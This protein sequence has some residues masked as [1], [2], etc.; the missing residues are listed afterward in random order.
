[1]T[2]D[3]L[4]ACGH[5]DR[6][7]IPTCA[8]AVVTGSITHV[9][10]CLRFTAA[11]VKPVMCPNTSPHAAH[12]WEALKPA[13]GTVL[14][15]LWCI[16]RSHVWRPVEGAFTAGHQYTGAP[17]AERQDTRDPQCVDRWPECAEDEYNP[18]C[19]RFPKSC[20]CETFA[21]EAQPADDL[22]ITAQ[23]DV[24]TFRVE[25]IVRRYKDDKFAGYMTIRVQGE[26]ASS[27]VEP[28]EQRIPATV[29]EPSRPEQRRHRLCST[30][31]HASGSWSA[32]CGCGWK[33]DVCTTQGEAE[34]AVHDHRD[35]VDGYFEDDGSVQRFPDPWN[36]QAGDVFR[37]R[38]VDTPILITAVGENS[39]LARLYSAPG[40]REFARDKRVISTDY[41][42]W[43]PPEADD[44]PEIPLDTVA[45]RDD[46]GNMIH[47]GRLVDGV[48]Q[49]FFRPDGEAS[50]D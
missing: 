10:G 8:A 50:G 42:P 13:P 28:V 16:G 33:S 14:P 41:I 5:P 6:L 35:E 29:E 32:T 27:K 22:R 21:R 23:A 15:Q 36:P 45:I 2:T 38:A 18:A 34:R 47:I 43:F 3:P 12:F 17:I 46:Y 37:T 11:D 7:H 39:V 31:S 30:I 49:P 40:S 44:L 24:G 19:C 25:T 20:S 4:C 48:F 1:M 9:C 26:H